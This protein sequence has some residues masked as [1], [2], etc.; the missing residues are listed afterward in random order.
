MERKT[1]MAA[2]A[3]LLCALLY[4][5]GTLLSLWSAVRAAEA[6]CAERAKESAE[7]KAAIAALQS[8]PPPGA[9][10]ARDALKMVF[11]QEKT[12]YYQP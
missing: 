1:V 3:L 5:L 4:A 11:P 12:V 7:L 8:A 2:R 10:A 6:V 9:E